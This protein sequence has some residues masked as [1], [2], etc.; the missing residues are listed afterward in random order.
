[1]SKFMIA[2]PICGRYNEA[3]TG[4]FASKRIHCTC[5]NIINVKTDKMASCRCANC[6]NDVVYD[7]SKAKDAKCPVCGEKLLTAESMNKRI[8]FRCPTCAC[9]LFAQKGATIY[10][11][12]VCDTKIDVAKEARLA[13]QRDKG[14]PAV[15]QYEGGANTL[16]W[17]HPM[18]DFV[19]GSQLIVHETQEAI[20]LRNGEALDSFPAGRYDLETGVLPKMNSLFK[21]PAQG[22]PFHAEVYFVNLTTLMNIKW[23]TS[24]KVGLFDPIS[25]LHVELGASG[26]FNLRVSDARRLLMRLVGTADA[27][28][29][30]QLF[31]G[32]TGYFRT[33]IMNRVK[34]NLARI[35]KD[36]HVN[37]LE[38]DERLDSISAHLQTAINENLAEY[39]LTMPEFFVSNIVTPDDDPNFR[40]LK[41]Q[42]ADLYLKT[43][44]E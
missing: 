1:M 41:Q 5:G 3:S 43:R 14:I 27:L 16:V 40:R 4:F 26:A 2:C 11:C 18:T 24:S 21:L 17:K 10:T 25:G 42:H 44:E 34:S 29:Q 23:G 38:L 30:D 32:E 8:T 37:V 12:P 33:L 13:E 35:I 20:F 31:S 6:G 28:T 7:Q 22:Q 9:E 36:N 19:M 39:G 15:I